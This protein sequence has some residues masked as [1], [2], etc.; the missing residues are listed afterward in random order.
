MLCSMHDSLELRF[1]GVKFKLGATESIKTKNGNVRPLWLVVVAS[2]TSTLFTI[3]IFLLWLRYYV[4]FSF[5]PASACI[6]GGS[7]V[8]FCVFSDET[9]SEAYLS[10][11]SS[12]YGTIITVLMGMLALVAGLAFLTIRAQALRQSEEAIE[13]E[14]KRYFETE[15]GRAATADALAKL[16]LDNTADLL[17]RIDDIELALEEAEIPSFKGKLKVDDEKAP[18]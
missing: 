1:Q 9:N 17:K 6:P 13:Y 14:V 18:E 3:L 16:S 4:D 15:T 8:H 2:A 10:I 7:K 11:I 12:F 5:F